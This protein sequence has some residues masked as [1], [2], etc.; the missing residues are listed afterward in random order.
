M[1]MG[2]NTKKV[3]DIIQWV[4]IA[5]LLGF[6]IYTYHRANILGEKYNDN[7]IKKQN[8][9]VRIYDSQTL[10]NLK[11]ENKELYDSIKKL[12]N[13]KQAIQIKWKYR[14][15][16]KEVPVEKFKQLP[17]SIYEFVDSNDTVDCKMRIKAQ[18]L[19]WANADVTVKD[20]FIIVSSKLDEDKNRVD[21]F[22]GNG[23][24][25]QDVTTFT[26]KTKVSEKLKNRFGVGP[27]F[28]VG[29]GL[30]NKQFDSYVGIAAFYKLW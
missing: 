13:V 14:Y 17:D 3:I 23:S 19:V 7:D 2:E 28:G 20:N 11:K 12:E 5:F 22:H 10:A 27:M 30:T 1:Q 15:L 4:L 6:C 16:T 9:F 26:P 18:G 25:I 29:Y 21:I 8:S 24:Q